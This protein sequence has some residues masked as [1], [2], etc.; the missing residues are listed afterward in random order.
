MEKLSTDPT[1]KTC[2]NGHLVTE[3]SVWRNANGWISQC[4][5]CAK[6]RRDDPKNKVKRA[7]HEREMRATDYGRARQVWQDLRKYGLSVTN[8]LN[9]LQFQGHK[10]A[11]CKNPFNLEKISRKGKDRP[12]IDH[13]H[14]NKKRVRALLCNYC[15]VGLGMFR[16]NSI[17]LN[18]ARNYLTLHSRPN[19]SI[20]TIT[21]D[22]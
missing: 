17:T 16:E 5:L 12:H 19:F 9:L 3:D 18:N 22:L 15:N 6:N 13:R 14:G 2:K 7:Q 21:R 10:C 1:Q 4:K 20:D 11:I 8:Y